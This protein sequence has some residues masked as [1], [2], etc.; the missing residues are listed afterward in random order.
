MLRKLQNREKKGFTLTELLIVIVI[1][2]VLAVA[3]IPKI[4]GYADKAKETGVVTDFR[5]IQTSVQGVGLLNGGFG[6]NAF[7]DED[8]VVSAINKDTDV[9]LNFADAIAENAV[10][11]V[12]IGDLISKQN[13]PWANP[14]MMVVDQTNNC[15]LVVSAGA[16]GKFGT[17]EVSG[18]GI[19]LPTDAMG[20]LTNAGTGDAEDNL[21]LYVGQVD[22]STVI[23]T[24]G[25]SKNIQ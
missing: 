14:Y 15:V 20:A 13:D 1:I 21:V 4:S 6:T 3:L 2:A 8:A 9:R 11:G 25:L 12:K 17:V 24:A 22:G 18:T 16:D 7:A 10:S 5:S 23:K 19:V